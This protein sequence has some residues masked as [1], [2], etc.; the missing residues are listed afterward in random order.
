M[1]SFRTSAGIV[2]FALRS[3]HVLTFVRV[4]ID[5][6]LS[7]EIILYKAVCYRT[8]TRSCAVAR[9]V[10]ANRFNNDVVKRGVGHFLT[11][12]VILISEHIH[13]I[14]QDLFK[15]ERAIPVL[16]VECASRV[17]ISTAARAQLLPPFS[18]HASL[19]V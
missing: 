3:A 2:S 14:Y 17:S 5:P 7:S 9:E 10:K 16:N 1:R 6:D 19:L 18:F 11:L 12:W 15:E 4:G 8:R 13:Q